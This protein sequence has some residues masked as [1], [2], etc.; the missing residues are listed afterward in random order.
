MIRFL[1][2]A[3]AFSL[4][5]VGKSFSYPILEPIKVW[6]VIDVTN[7][8]TLTKIWAL[9]PAIDIE[10]FDLTN[11]HFIDKDDLSGYRG[12]FARPKSIVDSVNIK[13]GIQVGSADTELSLPS[14]PPLQIPKWNSIPRNPKTTPAVF[15][16]KWPDNLSKGSL[17]TC[18]EENGR[19]G[20]ALIKAK[21]EGDESSFFEVKIRQAGYEVQSKSDPSLAPE[22]RNIG[23]HTITADPGQPDTAAFN[24]NYGGGD[25]HHGKVFYL[26]LH[27][28]ELTP[29]ETVRDKRFQK[30]PLFGLLKTGKYTGNANLLFFFNK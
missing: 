1:I 10:D 18:F 30:G 8:N 25:Y 5:A 27:L 9:K 19:C 24:L 4:P 16:F 20:K 26:L 12:R 22:L 29:N 23:W 15:Q 6:N 3:L 11:L 7:Q 17:H 13:L 2:A 21:R 14:G 28:L